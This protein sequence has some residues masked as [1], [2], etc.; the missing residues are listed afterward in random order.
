M[1]YGVRD[2]HL[3]TQ[4]RQTRGE[5]AEEGK[6][7]S[8][9]KRR[10]GE[11]STEKLWRLDGRLLFS[12]PNDGATFEHTAV[13]R[14]TTTNTPISLLFLLRVSFLLF[15]FPC[16]SPKVYTYRTGCF[17]RSLFIRMLNTA[18]KVRVRAVVMCKLDKV[19]LEIKLGSS[20]YLWG[21]P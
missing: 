17:T 18:I 6:R 8:Y 11:T 20:P 14:A 7:E 16:V 10:R 5:R 21:R 3:S 4:K 15:I 1:Q 19:R 2:A 9:L 13:V 12:I